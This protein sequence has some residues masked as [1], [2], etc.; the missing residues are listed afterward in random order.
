M[1]KII[2]TNTDIRQID[3][4]K[5]RPLFQAF[6]L[7]SD[8]IFVVDTHL[9][10]QF[11][12]EAL[13]RLMNSWEL[14]PPGKDQH[15]TEAIPFLTNTWIADYKKIFNSQESQ[16]ESVDTF[17]KDPTAYTI[18]KLPMIKTK[19]PN[20]VTTIIKYQSNDEKTAKKI[21][22]VE[23][24][25]EG[26]MKALRESEHKFRKLITQMGDGAWLFDSSQETIFIN[27]ALCEMLR[28]S[29]SELIGNK[30][31]DFMVET[32]HDK[33]NKVL[34]SL[35][36]QST[37]NPTEITFLNKSGVE[38]ETRLILSSLTDP[39]N[40]VV[41]NFCVISDITQ[42]K[43]LQELQERFIATT[44]HELQTPLTVLSGYIDVLQIGPDLSQ[45]DLLAI[46]EKMS[47]N[48]NRLVRLV[49]NVHDLS[50]VRANLFTIDRKDVNLFE[51]INEIKDQIA[52]L[53]PT[54]NIFWD[55]N[56]TSDSNLSFNLDSE[57]IKQTVENLTQNS[58]KNS[59]ED[60]SIN[61][62]ILSKSDELSIVVQDQGTGISNDGMLQ[63]F[64]PFAHK[65]TQYSQSG[66]GL[67]LY[68]IKAIIQ[69]HGGTIEVVSGEENTGCIFTIKLPNNID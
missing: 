43:S 33:F 23:K 40:Q 14:P 34:L 38:V 11:Y 52:I 27:K 36:T 64:R 46:I 51:F 59:P 8:P 20:L 63:L 47:R 2:T 31:T 60:S 19:N 42:E 68:I 62:R 25:Y 5:T 56:V 7:I 44:A 10:I 37:S 1:P 55:T 49:R 29:E 21:M 41:G 15:I 32:S 16:I 30:I 67:G 57:R 3:V 24:K 12:N 58:V 45:E 53:F 13:V 66:T 18:H 69:A 9:K 65:P 22:Y 4:S 28:F 35:D 61:I 26:M 48:V 50:A 39:D 54:R 17:P 6:S